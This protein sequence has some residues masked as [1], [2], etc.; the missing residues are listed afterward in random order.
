MLFIP[1]I[2]TWACDH[3]LITHAC[4]RRK[5]PTPLSNMTIEPHPATHGTGA[6]E[7]DE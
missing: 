4:R 2:M 6:G 1:V 7:L 3:A 5:S